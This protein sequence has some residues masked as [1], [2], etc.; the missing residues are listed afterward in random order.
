MIKALISCI[1]VLQFF[2]GGGGVY[3][4]VSP[5]VPILNNTHHVSLLKG[6]LG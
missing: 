2:L 6:N 5:L 1:Y 4:N 3:Q